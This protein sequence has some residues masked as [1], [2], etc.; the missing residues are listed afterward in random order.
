MVLAAISIMLLNF[1]VGDAARICKLFAQKLANGYTVW[2]RQLQKQWAG[3][4]GMPGRHLSEYLDVMILAQRTDA[5]MHL[6]YYPFVVLTLMIAARNQ[7]FANW[8]WPL[9]LLIVFAAHLLYAIYQYAALRN[10]AEDVRQ[11]AIK[12]IKIRIIRYS[13]NEELHRKLED[14]LQEVIDIQNGAFSPF[15]RNPVVGAVLIPFAGFAGWMLIQLFMQ[16]G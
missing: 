9:P 11:R 6:L 2:P 10:A 12:L 8:D 13:K 3:R 5:I 16:N 1:Y 15:T 7:Y 14:M 4:I